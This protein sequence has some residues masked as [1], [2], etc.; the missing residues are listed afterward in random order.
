MQKSSKLRTMF[1]KVMSIAKLKISKFG[2]EI[3]K[4]AWKLRFEIDESY[5]YFAL[6]VDT[7]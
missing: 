4:L 1:L 3:S 6:L 5:F 2:G 7:S